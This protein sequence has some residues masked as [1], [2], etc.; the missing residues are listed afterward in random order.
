LFPYFTDDK[1]SDNHE[2]TGSKTIVHVHRNDRQYLWE[3]FSNRFSGQYTTTK[4][5]YKNRTGNAIIFE[6]INEE[7]ELGFKYSWRFSEQ[8]GFV[9]QSTITNYANKEVSV[10]ILDGIQNIL[11]FGVGS[12]LQNERSNLV[13]AYKK[14]EL[15][16][17][18][19]LG[20]FRL[21]SMIVD[22]AEPSEALKVTTV[23]S[24][25]ID[26][27]NYLL[28]GKQ[29]EPFSLGKS[30]ETEVDIKAEPGA[31]FIS[32]E[33]HMKPKE[34]ESWNIVA[35]VN[36]DHSKVLHL[37]NRLGANPEQLRTDLKG[38]IGHGTTELKKMVG[39]ADGLQLT[40]DLLSTG[41]HYSNVLFNIMRGGIFEDQYEIDTKDLQDYARIIN[42]ELTSSTS[43]FSELPE[44]LKNSELLEKVL[45]TGDPDL[46]RI[47]Y[48]YIPLTFSRRHGDPSRPWNKFKIEIKKPDGSRNRQYEGNWRDIF[49]NWEALALSF[50]GYIESM[51]IKFVNASTIDGYNPYR[52]TRD[53]IDWEVIE[54][55]DPWSYIGYWGDH[56][57]IYLLKLLEVS[58]QHDPHRLNELLS[59]SI[60]VYANVPYRI[61]SYSDILKNPQDTI[62]YDEEKAAVVEERV[63]KL[64]ADGKLIHD[65]N[66]SIIRSNLTEKLLVTYLAKLSNFIPEAGIWLNTQRPEWNDAN[67]AL[68]GNGVSMVTLSYMRRFAT[69]CIDIF[70][71]ARIEE[72]EVNAHV[73]DLFKGIS[74][75][76]NENE[77]LLKGSFS[78]EQRKQIVDTLGNLGNVYRSAVYGIEEDQKEKISCPELLSFLKLTLKYIDHTIES[79]KR[80]DGLYHAYNLIQ[81]KEDAIT[82]SYLY[83]MLEGQVAVLSSGF[84]NPK[85]GLE[86]LDAL[87]N[88]SLYREDQYSYILYPDRELPRFLDT[89]SIPADFVES[90]PLAKELLK[91]RDRSVIN[92]DVIGG[93]HFS[94]DFNNAESLKAALARLKETGYAEL[95]EKEHDAYLE[96]FEDIFNHMA[97]TGRSGTFFGYEGLG[98][99]YWHMVSKLLLATQELIYTE[100]DLG[101]TNSEIFG[102]LVDHYYE[103]RAGIGINKSPELYG[104]FPTDPYSHTPGNKGAQQPGMTGQ[105]KED[106]INR[107][108]ELGVRVED[109]KI[110]F[111]PGFLHSEEFLESQGTFKYFDVNGIEKELTI[112]KGELVFTYCQVPIIYKKASGKSVVVK[113]AD[114]ELSFKD[115]LDG[116]TSQNI[117]T[118]NGKVVSVI[119]EISL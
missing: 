92:R 107:W 39:M 64:G 36:N 9:K 7:L 42:K 106:V 34:E 44:F 4:N 77:A 33:F 86:V 51:I 60:F 62:D 113:T 118:R 93:Y 74:K 55:D 69:F 101:N 63:N 76:F 37:I 41:R 26:V 65:A 13:N 99:I 88:S 66:Q 40:G 31:Y 110:S 28:S 67:N 87:K 96:V 46:I 95:V 6:E 15:D 103:I 98:S 32:S 27:K 91:N 115:Q 81:L 12:G 83:E 56:Q 54:P 89:N 82:V 10:R 94:G 75:C 119:V 22:K 72:F 38:D 58:H 1:I 8:F 111:K 25:G 23:W 79:N 3:P 19:G 78:D 52:I 84:L 35:E 47:C 49:Q 45:S 108:S 18:T 73:D 48:E 105:V 61:K 20:L 117:F 116:E 100:V 17:E 29:V 97:F 21:S 50:P 14:N 43:F 59:K 109:G 80:T 104:S 102:K 114:K 53:G 11:P 30:I 16:I 68:V 112:Q 85:E 70:E 90:S 2:I 57:I 71:G 24:E 5:L